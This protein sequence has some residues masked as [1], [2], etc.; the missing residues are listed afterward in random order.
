M[1]CT[2]LATSRPQYNRCMPEK[3]AIESLRKSA[4]VLDV[5]RRTHS[6]K[7]ESH[8]QKSAQR[9]FQEY[10]NSNHFCKPEQHRQKMYLRG[11]LG[12]IITSD[13]IL[14]LRNTVTSWSAIE[15]EESIQEQRR[16]QIVTNLWTRWWVISKVWNL[17]FLTLIAKYR[18]IE[19]TEFHT[20]GSTRLATWGSTCPD[21][22][23]FGWCPRFWLVSPSAIVYRQVLG[24][25]SPRSSDTVKQARGWVKLASKE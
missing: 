5:V 20:S 2:D 11:N 19:P 18:N 16:L 23:T 6:C 12:I 3:R 10:T 4:Q 9:P 13:E 21:I 8:V 25:S 14:V 24:P 22:E 15:K 7:V 1:I 17:G